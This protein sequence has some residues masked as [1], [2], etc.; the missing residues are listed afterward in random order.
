MIG[1][2]VQIPLSLPTIPLL[3]SPPTLPELPSFIPNINIE[4]PVLPPAPK[5][6]KIAPEIETVINAVSFFSEL[7]CIVKWGIG[8]VGESNVKTRIEQLTQRTYEIPLFDNI[9]LSTDMSYQQ[10]K[11]Q[12]FDF[13]IDAYVN[14]TMN[15]NGVYTLIKW[16]ADSINEQ[17]KKLTERE[18]DAKQA[19][20]KV[21][22]S[23]QDLNDT[24]QQNITIGNPLGFIENYPTE[25]VS[26]EQKNINK[27]AQ[28]LIDDDR[29]PYRTKEKITWLVQRLDQKAKFKPQTDHILAL[30]KRL[31]IL[32]HHLANPYKDYKIKSKTMIVLLVH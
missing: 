5:I 7:Y 6:P 29:T 28:F 11:L 4:L 23:A 1:I 20:S 18:G 9:N 14:F 10:D 31:I 8:L 13:Q 16:L 19:L 12:G 17:T 3:P 26:D 22:E 30:Q 27:V 32:L 25:S 24:T 21:N 2:W 15:F